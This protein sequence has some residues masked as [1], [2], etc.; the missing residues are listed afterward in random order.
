MV[1]HD[2]MLKRSDLIV[3]G[4]FLG[5]VVI[6]GIV[7]RLRF[8][9][10]PGAAEANAPMAAA[11][12][13]LVLPAPQSCRSD[14]AEP[15]AHS[16]EPVVPTGADASQPQVLSGSVR[17][18][19]GCAP[20]GGAKIEFWPVGPDA[21]DGHSKRTTLFADANG[22][23]RLRCDLPAADRAAYIYLRVSADGYATL[24]A[25]YQPKPSQAESE[26]DIVLE[27][28]K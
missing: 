17:S 9:A 24:M 23:Y 7:G 15:S 16:T 21:A 6:G 11:N 1:H 25:H 13:G 26:F 8:E 2:K 20:I 12:I 28:G 19:A 5:V 3:R 14:D 27:P 22:K 18:S 4:L 10:S